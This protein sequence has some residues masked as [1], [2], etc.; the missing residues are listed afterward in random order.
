[1]GCDSSLVRNIKQSNGAEWLI[2]PLG[3]AQ[4][5]KPLRNGIRQRQFFFFFFLFSTSIPHLDKAA[6]T[7]K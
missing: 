1:M 3:A 2:A 4:E 6:K 5:Q 7:G